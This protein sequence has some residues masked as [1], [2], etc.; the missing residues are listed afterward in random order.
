MSRALYF[1]LLGLFGCFVWGVLSMTSR[2]TNSERRPAANGPLKNPATVAPDPGFQIPSP[3]S[4]TAAALPQH[5]AS[6]TIATDS[7]LPG[8]LLG[9]QEDPDAVAD[10]EQV[11]T[12]AQQ[13]GQ[14]RS[15][16]APPAAANAGNTAVS[17]IPPET[18]RVSFGK[19]SDS[20]T[21]LVSPVA[22]EPSFEPVDEV[23]PEPA[24]AAVANVGNLAVNPMPPET[25]EAP[26]EKPQVSPV[27]PESPVANER[28]PEPADQVVHTDYREAMQEAVEDRK[29]LFIY[30]YE[31]GQ[32]AARESF[33]QQTLA[34]Q[35]IQE[36]LKRY[37]FVKLPRDAAITVDGKSISLLGHAAFAEMLGRQGV[38][39]VDLV[40]VRSEYYGHVVSTFPFTPG[41]F[42]R[43]Q[44]LSIILDLPPGT[45]TQRTMIYAVRIHPE[46]PA[47]TQ[48]QFHVVLAEEAK[49]SADHQASILVQ[50]HHSWDARFQ[51]INAKLPS[52]LLAQEVVAESWPNEGLVEACV[53]CVHSWRQSPGHW[54]AVRS[55]HPLF[56]YDIKRGRN[57]IWYAT[58]IFGQR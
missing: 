4:S 16:L 57:G 43:K 20:P 37:V 33:E 40:H 46:A 35:E 30:F 12:A 25:S 7:P 17:P 55:R 50:G 5:A 53:D 45:L 13:D 41:K 14:A 44:A 34:D 2:E 3:V 42:Y 26:I 1:I 51:R 11:A 22:N 52:G 54:G 23:N 27:P 24:P 29:M 28:A 31:P 58:G 48:G 47:S 39:I 21:P 38:S 15:E 10:D 49:M 56:G 6:V 19:L 18:P 9:P 36:K 8:H 32:N